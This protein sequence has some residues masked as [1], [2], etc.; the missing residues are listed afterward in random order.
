MGKGKVVEE[1]G[2][3][4]ETAHKQA[5]AVK[6]RKTWK[7]RRNESRSSGENHLSLVDRLEKLTR[8]KGR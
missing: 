6:R 2:A 8:R 7:R 4:A 3:V 1:D 5:K